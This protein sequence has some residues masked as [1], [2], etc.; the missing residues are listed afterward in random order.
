[1]I[2]RKVLLIYKNSKV[3][4]IIDIGN[5]LTSKEIENVMDEV[6][7]KYDFILPTVIFK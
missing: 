2:A 6:K 1:M 3:I 4:D 5:K 7:V